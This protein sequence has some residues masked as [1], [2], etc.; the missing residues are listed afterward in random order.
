MEGETTVARNDV[1][2]ISFISFCCF[3]VDKCKVMDSKMRPIWVVF[4]NEDANGDN[5]AEIFKNGDGELRQKFVFLW[6]YAWEGTVGTRR[7]CV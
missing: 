5:V 2:G 6:M 3:R 4:Q 1:L 7:V